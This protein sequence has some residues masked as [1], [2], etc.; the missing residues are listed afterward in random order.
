MRGKQGI[1][2]QSCGF[3]KEAGESSEQVVVL[4]AHAWDFPSSVGS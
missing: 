1:K 4:K 3:H 2:T